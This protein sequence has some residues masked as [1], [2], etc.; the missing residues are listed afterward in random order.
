MTSASA[1]KLAVTPP[2]VGSVSSEKYG[3]RLAFSWASAAAV[4]AICIKE[5]IP[6]CIRAPP[7]AVTI[8][9]GTRRL[10]AASIAFVIISPVAVP[11][12]P[13]MKAKSRQAN[14]SGS[15]PMA[16][17]PQMTAS[18]LP[19]RARPSSIRLA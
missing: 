10:V 19:Q 16:A 12:L 2:M 9:S 1:A 7:E 8:K 15:P 3:S 5:K 17:S 13:P 18:L 11:M 14:T 4:F 6:S